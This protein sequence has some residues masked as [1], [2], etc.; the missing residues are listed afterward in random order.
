[1]YRKHSKQNR[2]RILSAA[3][4]LLFLGLLA[5]SAA[6]SQTRSLYYVADGK[7]AAISP[8]LDETSV[9]RAVKRFTFLHDA[10]L[11]PNQMNAYIAI[12][13][14]KSYYLP[15]ERGRGKMDYN[16]LFDLVYANMSYASPIRL[17]DYL[18]KDSYYATDSHWRQECL[19]PVAEHIAESMHVQKTDFA[20]ET[21][22]AHDSFIGSYADA[23]EN[24][25]GREKRL[26]ASAGPDI[27]AYLTNDIIEQASV[28]FYD[29]DTFAEIYNWDK[30]SSRN[31]YDFFLSGPAAL[32]HLKNSA[33]ESNRQLVVFRDS[34]GS[35]LIPL[36]LP[37]Y[38]ELLVI[39]IRYTMSDRLGE[40]VDFSK[41]QGADA[42]YLY[43][44]TLLNRSVSLR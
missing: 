43:S 11:A 34:Y 37:Y 14:D 32:I 23:I 7:I 26:F 21:K 18:N 42:L 24:A 5:T 6:G 4:C 40:F 15:D 36:L 25:R 39:D 22:T 30:L 17:T 9:L 35:S 16:A 19:L 27:I 41:W 29:T 2:T 28:Y 31:P 38:K 1:M 3:V 10:Y 8:K 33:C 44:T 12:V 13:P 20:Y